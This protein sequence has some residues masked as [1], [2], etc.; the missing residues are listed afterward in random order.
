ME[1]ILNELLDQVK[2]LILE[3]EDSLLKSNPLIL[4]NLEDIQA[5]IEESL[6]ELSDSDD[7]D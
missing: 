2:E 4:E 6:E 5:L 3:Q 1:T 7:M